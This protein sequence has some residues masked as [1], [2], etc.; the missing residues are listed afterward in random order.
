MQK[1]NKKEEKK[2]YVQKKCREQNEKMSK[3]LDTQGKKSK[4]KEAPSKKVCF[5]LQESTSK[6]SDKSARTKSRKK[7]LDSNASSLTSRK[8]LHTA[9]TT[10]TPVKGKSPSDI[11]KPAK[12]TK[13]NFDEKLEQPTDDSVGKGK[14]RDCFK[15]NDQLRHCQD[16]PHNNS[17]SEEPYV[18]PNSQ[19][20]ER[21]AQRMS[22]P[23]VRTTDT[24]HCSNKLNKTFTI[25]SACP[26][27]DDITH[28]QDI[29]NEKTTE[30]REKNIDSKD[31]T[32]VEKDDNVSIVNSGI[33]S[34]GVSK[35]IP[36]KG[37]KSEGMEVYEECSVMENSMSLD[38]VSQTPDTSSKP[39]KRKKMRL[40]DALDYSFLD[41]DV[42]DMY[43]QI[44]NRRRET[45]RLSD[46]QYYVNLKSEDTSLQNMPLDASQ[47]QN[48]IFRGKTRREEQHQ[49]ENEDS[50]VDI[51]KKQPKKGRSVSSLVKVNASETEMDSGRF[52]AVPKLKHSVKNVTHFTLPDSQFA[53]LKLNRSYGSLDSTE[54]VPESKEV[55]TKEDNPA[56]NKRGKRQKKPKKQLNI[57]CNSEGQVTD[58]TR[59]ERQ[60]QAES[61]NKR[62]SRKNSNCPPKN[63][64]DSVNVTETTGEMNP[65]NISGSKRA[66]STK[67]RKRG[68]SQKQAQLVETTK[69]NENDVTE[70]VAN[71]PPNT[72][73]VRSAPDQS[74]TDICSTED[75]SPAKFTKKRRMTASH[76]GKP[77]QERKKRGGEG[78]SKRGGKSR[79]RGVVGKIKE[80]GSDDGTSKL[81]SSSKVK[82][83]ASTPG[84]EISVMLGLNGEVEVDFPTRF[85]SAPIPERLPNDWYEGSE[86]RNADDTGTT[87]NARKCNRNRNTSYVICANDDQDKVTPQNKSGRVHA[88]S[89]P[90]HTND[91]EDN[92][93]KDTS[94]ES[95]RTDGSDTVTSQSK[96]RVDHNSPRKM[97]D[98][99][100]SNSPHYRENGNKY[101]LEIQENPVENL[102]IN[103]KVGDR[104]E[105]ETEDIV[106]T[107]ASNKVKAIGK[108]SQQTKRRKK[109]Y[110]KSMEIQDS[111]SKVTSPRKSGQGEFSESTDKQKMQTREDTTTVKMD[112]YKQGG[113]VEI[114]CKEERLGDN[115]KMARATTD[116]NEKETEQLT[117]E[118]IEIIGT[119]IIVERPED[120][121]TQVTRKLSVDMEE[122]TTEEGNV[123]AKKT[124]SLVVEKNTSF[125]CD[126]VNMKSGMF[127]QTDETD[128]RDAPE[129]VNLVSITEGKG[130]DLACHNT[131]F[132]VLG[133]TNK[134]KL[135]ERN[136]GNTAWPSDD[137]FGLPEF[138]NGDGL[139]S[140]S[141]TEEQKDKPVL[142]EVFACDTASEETEFALEVT[143]E[144]QDFLQHQTE[145]EEEFALPENIQMISP[146]RSEH[147]LVPVEWDDEEMRDKLMHEDERRYGP[148]EKIGK[149]VQD[150]DQ[151]ENSEHSCTDTGEKCE[152]IEEITKHR[153]TDETEE[154]EFDD[155]TTEIR[156]KLIR[157]GKLS[158]L[159]DNSEKIIT[160]KLTGV[161]TDAAMAQAVNLQL[162][163]ACIVTG[164]TPYDSG[165]ATTKT[166]C[167]TENA[168]GATQQPVEEGR[169]ERGSGEAEVRET[170]GLGNCSSDEENNGKCS[171]VIVNIEGNWQNFEESE[172]ENGEPEDQVLVAN[173][174]LSK[175]VVKDAGGTHVEEF[176]PTE[177]QRSIS[178]I[179]FDDEI[180]IQDNYDKVISNGDDG[181][182]SRDEDSTPQPEDRPTL[183]EYEIAQANSD[184]SDENLMDDDDDDLNK[185]IDL[186]GNIE[187]DQDGQDE[188]RDSATLELIQL[189]QRIMVR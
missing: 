37:L 189:E 41:D 168:V 53:Q 147:R 61:N 180:V 142:T 60:D 175:E 108:T 59:K 151:P 56:S 47:K 134:P 10:P 186:N 91:S 93:H 126:S 16:D 112:S 156:T 164:S 39:K 136:H 119:A 73:Q 66:P 167:A 87:R 188:Q 19:I 23:S 183:E 17:D 58:K 109:G 24:V 52:P 13:L 11:G 155:E 133:E 7:L 178:D 169:F 182:Q 14:E 132:E 15:K 90:R 153:A 174:D 187:N 172:K 9:E 42:N 118:Q 51:S 5:S 171:F 12:K 165:T 163:D 8:S 105:P 152:E 107:I 46:Y 117:T 139:L 157:A 96:S 28:R 123:P 160:G 67:G 74:Q 176:V 31:K 85:L 137:D 120:S 99:N 80:D 55:A 104:E 71:S 57:E 1:I 97:L 77:V 4:G 70:K 25:S 141:E 129:A 88:R 26:E 131:Q 173:R 75:I 121:G 149:M 170:V 29:D 144:V 179:D 115:E 128:Q 32:V 18:I 100:I 124:D 27:F 62:R 33:M 65:E 110:S 130:Q 43:S 101:V 38:P 36:G 50:H 145:D 125:V 72:C 154:C 78:N 20:S 48:N 140:E 146:V 35:V 45:R 184:D 3:S 127:Q 76:E 54:L 122:M 135:P 94:C 113:N 86:D 79:K 63:E 69:N 83:N 103:Q 49:S 44:K 158:S 166:V 64:N 95:Q 114:E 30:T 89:K 81:I 162:P 21:S 68:R 82:E 177:E 150:S 6:S 138:K 185:S 181:I 22:L 148:K 98:T 102:L 2:E 143:P 92:H 159:S 84:E 111:N 116:S 161:T 106:L 40:S 34:T